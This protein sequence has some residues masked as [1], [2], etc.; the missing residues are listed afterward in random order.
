MPSV[1][2]QL[3]VSRP[4]ITSSTITAAQGLPYNL[5]S[6]PA[7]IMTQIAEAPQPP[8]LDEEIEK[9]LQNVRDKLLKAAS[10]LVRT[11]DKPADSSNDIALM[12]PSTQCNKYTPIFQSPSQPKPDDI[13]LIS[14]YPDQWALKRQLVVGACKWW[15]DE[16]NLGFPK[17]TVRDVVQGGFF[18]YLHHLKN[19][20]ESEWFVNAWGTLTQ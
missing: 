4:A 9:D 13:E 15:G 20:N 10:V 5:R 11:A 8:S 1:S 2:Q 17:N 18:V 6:W 14:P 12:Q 19:Y 7:R 16:L 3:Y